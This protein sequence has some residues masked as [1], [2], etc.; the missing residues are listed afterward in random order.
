MT[1]PATPSS[2]TRQ[3]TSALPSNPISIP[4]PSQWMSYLY[5]TAPHFFRD[6]TTKTNKPTYKKA[7]GNTVP[8]TPPN[9]HR[10]PSNGHGRSPNRHGGPPN[11]PGGSPNGPGGPQFRNRGPPSGPPRGGPNP[12]NLNSPPYHN[13]NGPPSQN[14]G[15]GSLPPPPPPPPG[16]NPVNGAPRD[17][18]AEEWQLNPK[19][20]LAVL[21]SWDGK[22]SSALEYLSAMAKL[23]GLSLK[24][25]IGIAQFAEYKWTERALSW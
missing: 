15:S 18:S 17:N 20:N 21:P 5:Q 24:M 10:E 19:L 22:G 11:G 7:G 14:P 25:N 16:G 2:H 13:G 3:L 6:T 23:V 4:P 1:Q 9:G 8:D 12:S